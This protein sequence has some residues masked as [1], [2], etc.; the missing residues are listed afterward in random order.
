[1]KAL[2]V[3]GIV[4]QFP[5]V[6]A[7]DNINLSIN[8]GEI[9]AIVGEN[10]A[11]KSTLM[12]IIYGLYT[13][14]SGEIFVFDKK[15]DIKTPYDAI[16][17]KIGMVHQEF[18]L[19]PRFTVTQNIV[20]GDEPSK[21]IV[22]DYK[23]ALNEVE[24]LSE[25][26]GLK[27][28][29][30][31]K[32][33]NLPVGIQQRV[34]ILKIL[35]RGAEILIFDEPT[36]VLTPEET[37]DL[38]KTLIKL[39][40][41]GKTIIFISHKL[42]EVIAIA[43][44]IAVLRR[45]K[46]QGIVERGKT[47]EVELAR[48]VVGRDV[49]LK[50]PKAEAKVGGTVVSIR[51]LTV[52]SKRGIIGLKEVSFDVCAGEIVGIA[53]VE[54]NGQAE[55]VNALIGFTRPIKG[56]IAFDGE[57]IRVITPF[58]I[59]KKGMAYIPK[60]RK[61]R[62]LVLPFRSR[63]NIIMGQHT[64]YPFSKNGVLNNIEI[65]KFTTKKLE[66]FD[67]R[68]RDIHTR[69][70]NLSGGNQQKLILAKEMSMEHKFLLASQPTRGLDIG[71]MEFVYHKLIEEKERGMAILL[72]SLELSEIMGLSDRILV[73]YNGEIV[74]ET[75]PDKTTEEELGLMMLGLKK[76]KRVAQ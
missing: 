54:G 31:E 72:I 38:F 19:I 53:G 15:V 44:R 40:K 59:R 50:I 24:E 7:N 20:L 28:N 66:E 6:L 64:L 49:V 73:L 12:K 58:N 32:V 34:E 2:E 60:D 17:L 27:V 35:R 9:Y 48:M 1:M 46:L 29:P 47:S 68:P 51:D 55:L 37:E 42:K 52:K 25:K 8:K 74:G 43:D 36:A 18:M 23:K 33:A 13:P 16:G 10:G 22:F 5:G 56:T 63:E 62:G 65:D 69:A 26:F 71:A 21:G 67:V 76:Q 57:E 3:K 14:T 45:G 30:A 4:K 70:R 11:G 61:M 41:N 75:T 39:K